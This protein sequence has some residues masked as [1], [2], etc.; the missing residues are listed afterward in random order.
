MSL[1][2]E[3]GAAVQTEA[4]REDTGVQKTT[5]IADSSL[6]VVMLTDDLLAA[7]EN[8]ENMEINT[9]ERNYSNGEAYFIDQGR[10]VFQCQYVNNKAIRSTDFN[11]A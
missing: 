5:P 2:A 1:T 7:E 4:G 10:V 3:Q 8:V 6:E 11:V 9:G